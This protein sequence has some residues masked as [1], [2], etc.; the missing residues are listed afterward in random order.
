MKKNIL[1]TGATG[2]LGSHLLEA[3]L[4]RKYQVTILKRSS[5]DT[6][7]INHMLAF[8]SSYDI[9]KQPM[10]IAFQNTQIDAVIHTATEYG[11]NKKYPSP[12]IAANVL[13]PVKLIETAIRF[14]V[15]AFYNADSF[16][17]NRT[18][19][20]KYLNHYSL[21][22][23]QFVEW[24]KG[25]A[26]ANQIQVINLKIQ[27]M[28]GSRDNHEKFAN[29]LLHEMLKGS[30]K[31][32]LTKGEQK[33]DFIHVS[34]VARAFL[35]LLKQR[36]N[37]GSFN[38]YYVGSGKVISVR[39]FIVLMKQA[40]DILRKEDVHI[41]LDFGALPYREG[42]FMEHVSG[43]SGLLE[44]GWQPVIELK[45]GL[46]EMVSTEIQCKQECSA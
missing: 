22:K 5:S 17:N 34:D 45:N 21:S 40:V 18:L 20:Y 33:R 3:L 28:Y 39:D 27:H 38:E 15:P 32:P 42:E 7:R 16:F 13:F 44:L 31:I 10:E 29:W 41:H 1:L 37:L 43:V 4:Q 8:V 36:Q 23:R 26:E 30:R 46:K 24:L 11:R 35:F 14:K 9:D 12:V 2:F 25:F 19:D 6:W